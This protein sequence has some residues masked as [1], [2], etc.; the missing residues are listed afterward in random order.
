MG[1]GDK[2]SKRGKIISKSFG[3]RRPARK[4]TGETVANVNMSNENSDATKA[5]AKKTTKKPSKKE[6]KE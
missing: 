4:K 6:T 1:K 5:T 2:K 3:V